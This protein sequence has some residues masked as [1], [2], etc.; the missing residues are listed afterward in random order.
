MA[1]CVGGELEEL[2]DL[3]ATTDNFANRNISTH[4]EKLKHNSSITL[5]RK[6]QP[7]IKCEVKWEE[8][9]T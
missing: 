4:R 7:G 2:L 6:Q 3:Q 8:L 1:I 5:T 9:W